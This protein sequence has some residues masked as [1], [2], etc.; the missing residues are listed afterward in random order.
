M[1]QQMRM[2]DLST[3]ELKT[4]KK[5]NTVAVNNEFKAQKRY[6]QR[7]SPNS[8]TCWIGFN[9][10]ELFGVNQ[11]ENG[12]IEIDL[13]A[14][15]KSVEL[16]NSIEI[17]NYVGLS[18]TLRADRDEENFTPIMTYDLLYDP[19]F[20]VNKDGTVQIISK[21]YDTTAKEIVNR[22]KCN[23]T[24]AKQQKVIECKRDFSNI[25]EREFVLELYIDSSGFI[26][27]QGLPNGITNLGVTCYM[28]SY[29]Q[30]IFHLKKFRYYINQLE[31]KDNNDFIFCLQ[32]LFYSLENGETEA[33]T[34]DLVKAFGWNLEQMFMQQDV[35]EFSLKLLDAIEERSKQQGV[36]NIITK[37]LFRGKLE[38]YIKCVKV[39]FESKRQEDFYEL[40]LNI[41]ETN[42]IQ[43]ALSELLQHE[44]LFGDNA[45]DTEKFGKQDAIK[46][47][48]LVKL[49]DVL[50][51]NINRSDY[52]LE[53]F[54]PVKLLKEFKFDEE[55]DM[56]NYSEDGEVYSLFAVFVHIGFDSGRGHYTVFIKPDK[57][58]YE[59]NDE[60]VTKT[61]WPNVAKQ[62]YGGKNRETSFDLKSFELKEKLK[63]SASHA[64][65]LVYV[66]KNKIYE[67]VDNKGEK[68]EY[69]KSVIEYTENKMKQ[70]R[71][72]ILMQDNYKVY[73]TMEDTFIGKP[74][75]LGELFYILFHKDPNETQRFKKSEF[76][77]EHL[78]KDIRASEL[79]D[80]V[81]Q[82]Y[83]KNAMVYIFNPK[84]KLLR[85]VKPTHIHPQF[86]SNMYYQYAFLYK[87]KPEEVNISESCLVLLK[88]YNPQTDEMILK[89]I[90]LQDFKSTISSIIQ[91]TTEENVSEVSVFYESNFKRI[92]L[93]HQNNLDIQLS[94]L[95]TS[96]VKSEDVMTLIYTNKSED[97]II[98]LNEHW[99]KIKDSIFVRLWIDNDRFEEHVFNL[100]E[101]ANIVLDHLKNENLIDDP[102]N[103]S[104]TI[105]IG[106]SQTNIPY[107]RL[108]TMKVGNLVCDD[109]NV[110]INKMSQPIDINLPCNI[111]ML[112]IK[113]KEYIKLEKNTDKSSDTNCDINFHQITEI[114]GKNETIRAVLSENK[115]YLNVR[116]RKYNI[117]K[118]KPMV[119]T[120]CGDILDE[121]DQSFK[122]KDVDT[123][124]FVPVI[125]IEHRY[126]NSK[127]EMQIK[128]IGNGHAHN[129]GCCEDAPI[130]INLH[131]NRA[132]N[133]GYVLIGF[134]AERKMTFEEL[135]EFIVRFIKR[136]NI[137]VDEEDIESEEGV[138]AY[139]G[140]VLR[141]KNADG[142]STT[143][144]KHK[145]QMVEDQAL[146]DILD[147]QL[148]AIPIK[149]NHIEIELS[150]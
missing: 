67:V 68:I 50:V 87:P 98:K 147:I 142:E 130:E 3:D 116:Y 11:K 113:E 122:A 128:T 95:L 2:L 30:T 106:T 110:S 77:K 133:L 127:S 104:V 123:I 1:S 148:S 117:V 112:N 29:I 66:R 115:D 90:T 86:D 76:T 126:C 22:N 48:N 19:K 108:S 56:R 20:E 84:R 73:F 43:G 135:E 44:T 129:N 17:D 94:S 37:E 143:I 125:A 139:D 28:N 79:L 102:N 42:D 6:V 40:Q 119:R 45:Y 91:R 9:K 27:E 25:D 71:K 149:T 118:Y 38:T 34:L 53:T 78:D 31:A 18:V 16:I 33:H 23:L 120:T 58:W 92:E 69:P 54:E 65:M 137:L 101:P 105:T 5:I 72:Q 141:F 26:K 12:T 10:E 100:Y 70:I 88:Q 131:I 57:Q 132:T 146:N 97:A 111:E 138:E 35:Q 4:V 60:L 46:G 114:I 49:P 14:S 39:S 51:F 62:S 99:N 144:N 64:Y 15:E 145:T 63:D 134:I 150:R 124:I 85:L 103:Y 107:D 59:F 136:T 93:Y 8:L 89:S 7:Y 52:N 47:I 109:N 61:D 41:K 83:D 121:K 80:Y 96:K 36:E 24:S 82:K 81:H 75:G 140:I 13:E 32:S 55:I 21:L 74:T